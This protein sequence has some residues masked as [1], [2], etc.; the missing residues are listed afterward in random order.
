MHDYEIDDRISICPWRN[1]ASFV[2]SVVYDEAFV[3]TLAN[4]YPIHERYGI[5]GHLPVVSGQLGRRRNC[6]R[7]SLNGFFHMAISELRFLI[8]R[9]WSVGNHS[10]SDFVWPGQPGLDLHR[11]IVWSKWNLEDSLG[12][13]ITYFTIPNIHSNHEPS[14]PYVK[15]AGYLGCKYPVTGELNTC[16]FDPM[17]VKGIRLSTGKAPS[18]YRPDHLLT[19]NITLEQVAGTWLVETTHLVQS[20]PIQIHKNVSDPYETVR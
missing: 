16:D 18:G 14:L 11:E 10:Y 12:V 7:S 15:K 19:E 8:D 20:D 4:A 6:F 5:P 3:E 17:K 13:P 1:D 9:G 2:Y